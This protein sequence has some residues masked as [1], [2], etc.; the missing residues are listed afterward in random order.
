M[1]QGEYMNEYWQTAEIGT[2]FLLRLRPKSEV[3][4][5]GIEI[6]LHIGVLRF[7]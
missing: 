5:Y 2:S 7:R 6:S 4:I 3:N 1:Y